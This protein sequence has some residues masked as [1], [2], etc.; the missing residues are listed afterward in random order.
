M[1]KRLI[2][3]HMIMAGYYGIRLVVCVCLFVVHPSIF[4]FP[5]NYLSKC[6]WIFTK[7]CVCIDIV[8]I[9]LG[10]ANGQISSICVTCVA[11]QTYRDHVVCPRRHCHTFR[12][13]SIT[14]E[15]MHC[16][17]SDF[18]EVY[19]TVKYRSSSILV[20]ICQILAELWPFFIL[21]VC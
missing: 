2:P 4:S 21:L 13:G 6:Q 7:I 15:G 17:Y 5:D 1:I 3:H 14:F 9:R 8:E 12:F 20:I 18:A 16:F 11:W 10:T 19:I